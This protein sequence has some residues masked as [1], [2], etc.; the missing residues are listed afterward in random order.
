MSEQVAVAISHM[1]AI[2]VIDKDNPSYDQFDVKEEELSPRRLSTA[3]YNE[4][5][6]LYNECGVGSVLLIPL[7]EQI[8]FFNM[9]NVLE[10]RGLKAGEDFML[11]RMDRDAAGSVLPKN[12]R[13][14]KLKKLTSVMARYVDIYDKRD[15][16]ST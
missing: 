14:A 6:E 10:G 9:K 16:D 12:K 8:R 15:N 13:P 4:V 3:F 7:P 5:I 1:A 11:V 2:S